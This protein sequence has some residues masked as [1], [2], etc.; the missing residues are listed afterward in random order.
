MVT[1]LGLHRK[2]LSRSSI[3]TVHLAENKTKAWKSNT[4]TKKVHLKISTLPTNIQVTENSEAE[5]I[6]AIKRNHRGDVVN[7]QLVTEQRIVQDVTIA[8]T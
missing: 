6:Q 5:M 7:V 3:S 4:N 8:K 1:V 2:T